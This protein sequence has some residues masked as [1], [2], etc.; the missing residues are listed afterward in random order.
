VISLNTRLHWKRI[1]A[2]TRPRPSK[3]RQSEI[4]T[5]TG[6]K[7]SETQVAEFLKK[8][9]SAVCRKS[10]NDSAKADPDKQGAYPPRNEPRLAEAHAGKRAVFFVDAAHFVLAPVLGFLWSVARIL[11]QAPSGRQRFIVFGCHECH[12]A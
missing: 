8:T 2:T 11:H 1:F 9:P 4:E 10:R 5:L 3:K 7:R 6:I 12:H